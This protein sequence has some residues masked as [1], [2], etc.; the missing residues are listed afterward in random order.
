MDNKKRKAQRTVLLAMFV[1]WHRF[2]AVWL[3]IRLSIFYADLDPYPDPTPHFTI[4][5]NAS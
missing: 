3:R 1:D 4:T 5:S 2:D